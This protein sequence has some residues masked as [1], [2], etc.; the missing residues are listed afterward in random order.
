MNLLKMNAQYP[1]KYVEL[2]KFA[3]DEKAL[4]Q[5]IPSLNS[6]TLPNRC[7]CIKLEKKNSFNFLI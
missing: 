2:K 7:N 5:E 1:M 3:I 4:A 6:G